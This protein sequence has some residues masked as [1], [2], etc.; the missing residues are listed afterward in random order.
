M[1]PRLAYAHSHGMV[2]RDIKPENILVHSRVAQDGFSAEGAIKLTDFG[3]GQQA[4]SLAAN[5]IAY[6]ASIQKGS[7]LAGTIAYMAPEQRAGGQLDGR[8]D[9]Y[10]CG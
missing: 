10:S 6:T 9:I 1:L 7:E 2:H 8:S 5:S 4:T 3:L